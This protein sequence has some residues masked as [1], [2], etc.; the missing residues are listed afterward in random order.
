MKRLWGVFTWLILQSSVFGCS[1]SQNSAAPD[2][3]PGKEGADTDSDGS[4]SDMGTCA[5]ECIGQLQ[6]TLLGGKTSSEM[7]CESSL[8]VCC[9]IPDDDDTAGD[10]SEDSDQTSTPEPLEGDLKISKVTIYQGVEIPL[11]EDGAEASSDYAEVVQ[12][13]DA[14]L[15]VFVECASSWTQGMVRAELEMQ[16]DNVEEGTSLTVGKNISG[17]SASSSPSSTFN[18][19]IP[20]EYLSGNF[21]YRVSLVETGDSQDEE[22]LQAA[23]PKTGTIEVDEQS[24]GGA[25]QLI[26]VPVEYNADGSGRVPDTGE[27]MLETIHDLFYTTYPVA[28]DDIEITVADTFSWDSPVKADGDGWEDLLAALAEHKEDRGGTA[29]EY[30]FGLFEPSTSLPMYCFNGCVAGLAYVPWSARQGEAKV[31]LGLGFEPDTAAET[32]IHEIGHNHGREH[33]P[34]GDVDGIDDDFPYPDGGIGVWGYDLLSG[35]LRNPDI[36]SDFMGYCNNIWVSD[37]TFGALFDWI[38]KTNSSALIRGE[39]TVRRALHIDSKGNVK[40]GRTFTSNTPPSGEAVQLFLYDID[41]VFITETTGRFTPHIP[42]SGGM[43]LFEEPSEDVYYVSIE[44]GTLT[45]IR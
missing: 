6:C 34:C 23:W 9:N 33:A 35:A 24:P 25:L 37:Y 29:Q 12:K 42:L 11:M 40:I 16:G 36:Y 4:A 21:S 17:D 18:F 15:R 45:A 28:Y 32:M 19:D 5:Y 7:E 44:D 41:G 22:I 27:D 38:Q 43:V 14:M 2:S 30:Y 20:G 13:K 8:K 1:D 26:I 10:T 31:A 39:E 3:S